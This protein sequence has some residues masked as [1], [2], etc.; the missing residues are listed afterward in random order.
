MAKAS[1]AKK[2]VKVPANYDPTK[3][4]TYMSPKMLAFFKKKLVD[5]KAKTADE[6]R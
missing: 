6:T 3:D 1:K 5:W 4:K 2:P